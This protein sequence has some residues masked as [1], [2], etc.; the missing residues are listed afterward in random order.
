M[1]NLMFALALVVP[2][3]AR[4]EEKNVLAG[5][6]AGCAVS[7]ETTNEVPKSKFYVF[8]FGTDSS[9]DLVVESYVG[10]EKCD[11]APTGRVDYT[12][13]EVL[14][15]TGNHP[16]RFITAQEVRTKLFYKFVIAKSYSAIT[17]STNYPVKPDFVEV[18]VLDRVQ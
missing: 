17:S 5:Q 9:L 1:K 14:D 16:G 3:M 15:D 2:L 8:T 11:N 7:L 4:A 12:H 18:M 6:Y 10:T 13:F